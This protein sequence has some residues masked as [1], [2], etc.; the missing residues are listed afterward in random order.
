M[1]ILTM[2]VA[3]VFLAGLIDQVLQYIYSVRVKND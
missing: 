2:F 1:T 3:M